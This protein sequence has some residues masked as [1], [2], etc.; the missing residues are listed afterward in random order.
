MR[1]ASLAM[2]AL[3]SSQ[4]LILEPEAKSYIQLKASNDYFDMLVVIWCHM[5]GDIQW[6]ENPLSWNT[7]R[8]FASAA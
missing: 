7:S 8:G 3:L 6:R 1:V 2:D 5:L 4:H